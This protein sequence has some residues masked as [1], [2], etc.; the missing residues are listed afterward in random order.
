VEDVRVHVDHTWHDITTGDVKDSYAVANRQLR[1]NRQHL[2]AADRDVRE[3]AEA[4]LGIN[5]PPALEQHL[6]ESPVP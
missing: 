6:R 2:T 5:H 4:T 1:T 3:T